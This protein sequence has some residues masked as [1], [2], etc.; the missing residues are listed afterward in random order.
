[1]ASKGLSRDLEC[2]TRELN[3]LVRSTRLESHVNIAKKR[4]PSLLRSHE[5]NL[6]VAGPNVFKSQ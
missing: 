2:L 6:V 4:T 5:M 3:F 1:M